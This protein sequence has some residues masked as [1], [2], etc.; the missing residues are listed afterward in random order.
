M[1]SQDAGNVISEPQILKIFR[2][3]MPLDPARSH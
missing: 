3:G 1:C 2:G